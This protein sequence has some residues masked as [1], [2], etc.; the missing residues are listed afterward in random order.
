MH[1]K[2]YWRNT[3]EYPRLTGQG[4]L[5]KLPGLWDQAL[6]CL[7][8]LQFSISLLLGSCFALSL[9]LSTTLLQSSLSKST[10]FCRTAVTVWTGMWPKDPSVCPQVC[11]SLVQTASQMGGLTRNFRFLQENLLRPAWHLCPAPAL[12]D[13]WGQGQVQVVQ[14]VTCDSM[15]LNI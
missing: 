11:V 7:H 5:Q 2:M 13:L 3:E 15:K 1:T 10:I 4:K 8:S 14:V 9:P 6:Q 12:Q